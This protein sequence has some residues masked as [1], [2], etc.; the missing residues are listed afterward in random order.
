MLPKK[1]GSV[2]RTTV[3]GEVV[4]V[5]ESRTS[6]APESFV[7]VRVGSGG[8]DV[9]K[10]DVAKMVPVVRQESPIATPTQREERA[11]WSI[12]EVL[13]L[14][15]KNRRRIV[16]L[17]DERSQG[18]S[19]SCCTP[20]TSSPNREPPSALILMMDI[21]PRRRRLLAASL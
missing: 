12:I 11:C 10:F 18:K 4:E 7:T 17:S 1:F 5:H 21:R 15:W 2:F 16:R 19:I 9:G 13:L 6:P 14:G 8:T 3:Y 20:A